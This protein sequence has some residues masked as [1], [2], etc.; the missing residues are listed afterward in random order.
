MAATKYTYSISSDFP[1]QKEDTDRLTQEIADSAIVTALDY[2]DTAGDDCDI[3]F[4][5]ALSGGDQTTLDTIVANHSGDPLPVVAD[6]YVK[7]DGETL[8]TS[9]SWQTKASFS[10]TPLYEGDHLITYTALLSCS[11]T[12]VFMKTHITV[13]GTEEASATFDSSNK[14]HSDGY[15]T[16]VSRSVVVS[17]TDVVTITLEFCSSESGKTTYIKEALVT[18]LPLG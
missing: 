15:Y 7:S 10:Y 17:L 13:G 14:N 5:D 8:T 18:V 1:N 16:D 6:N 2:I 11:D 12:G 9:T 4:V 3:W